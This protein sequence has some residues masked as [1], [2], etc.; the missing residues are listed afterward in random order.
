LNG[1]NILSIKKI[2]EDDHEFSAT[3]L[4]LY[5]L[6]VDEIVEYVEALTED[7]TIIDLGPR[8][9]IIVVFILK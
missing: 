8:R 4:F 2:S 6:S 5:G 1:K 9:E 7:S 3:C